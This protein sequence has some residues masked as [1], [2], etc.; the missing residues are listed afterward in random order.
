M[1][2]PVPR[3]IARKF[4]QRW[5]ARVKQAE[6]FQARTERLKRSNATLVEGVQ[7]TDGPSRPDK[8][9]AAP[10]APALPVETV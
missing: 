8:I 7:S 9:E 2:S 5:S 10:P 6:S 1:S 4:E 3:D